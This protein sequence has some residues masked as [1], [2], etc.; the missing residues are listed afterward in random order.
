MRDYRAATDYGVGRLATAIISVRSFGLPVPQAVYR[1][2]QAVYSR[3]DIT[4]EGDGP[5]SV[6][7][8]WDRLHVERVASLIRYIFADEDAQSANVYIRTGR[9]TG[10]WPKPEQVGAFGTF[11]AIAWRPLLFGPD[12]AYAA[13]SVYQINALRLMFKN[14]V[15]V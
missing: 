9:Q 15:S 6:E 11:S 10:W 14:L 5:P 7:W 2:F 13:D 8:I 12:G 1:P 4:R 3:G